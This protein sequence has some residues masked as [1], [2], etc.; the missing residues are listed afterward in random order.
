MMTRLEL[1]QHQRR[2]EWELARDQQAHAAERLVKS[3]THDLLN[4]IQIVDLASQELERRG[5][6]IADVHELIADVRGAADIAKAALTGLLQLAR[7]AEV[8][9]RGASVVPV[10][11]AAIE[12]V[13]C[14]LAVDCAVG[15]VATACTA[16]ELEHLVIGLLLDLDA[17][18]ATLLVRT[19][20]IDG[21]P[22][23]E[24]VRGTAVQEGERFELRIVGAIVA[25]HG[26]ELAESERR[27]GGSELIVAL[28]MLQ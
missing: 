25:R 10:I 11:T 22:W 2:F 8:V 13:G 12:A 28:P 20:K 18:P 1:V 6:G 15:D 27:G 26:G 3:R 21:K 16:E 7:P 24:L 23:L 4:L 9:A 17:G 19:R 14:E 5:A